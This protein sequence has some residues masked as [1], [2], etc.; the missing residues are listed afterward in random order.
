MQPEQLQIFVTV[1]RCGSFTAAAKQLYISHSTTS[2]AI[3]A[4][5][6]ELGV[7][8]FYRGNRVNGLTAAGEALLEEAVKLLD[9]AEAAKT[10][11]KA[12]AEREKD[13]MGEKET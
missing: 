12:A 13:N 11:V 9:A 3:S 8:L 7:R 4:L 5:E 1:A 6:D 2:R 10:R